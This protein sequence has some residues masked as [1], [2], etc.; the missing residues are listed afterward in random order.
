MPRHAEKVVVIGAE[1]RET[2]TVKAR[3]IMST[4]K[5]TLHSFVR[6]DRLAT[7]HDFGYL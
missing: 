4:D 1:D 7:E 6:R 3:V 2:T 5:E